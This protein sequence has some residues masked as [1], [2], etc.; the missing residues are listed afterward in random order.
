MSD[1]HFLLRK[2]FCVSPALHL[3]LFT[4]SCPAYM[5]Y[6]NRHFEG[7]HRLL[8]AQHTEESFGLNRKKCTWLTWIWWFTNLDP[9]Q[10][11]K[12]MSSNHVIDILLRRS[13]IKYFQELKPFQ[14]TNLQFTSNRRWYDALSLFCPHY[15]YI[16]DHVKL[17][18][19]RRRTVTLLKYAVYW[20][21]FDV[22]QTRNNIVQ[23]S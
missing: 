13:K 23:D 8:Y 7:S 10:F 17:N 19:C 1:F 21:I 22:A 11:W 9:R 4:Y 2:R 6:H 14:Q 3:K 15:H 5:Y 12:R 16:F 20:L 18:D